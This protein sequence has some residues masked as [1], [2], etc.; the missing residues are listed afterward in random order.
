V[1]DA[2]DRGRCKCRR[3]PNSC[4]SFWR[5]VRGGSRIP[6]ERTALPEVRRADEAYAGPAEHAPTGNG[7]RDP[8][9]RLWECWTTVSRTARE[10]RA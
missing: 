10:Y 4:G 1:A 8:G 2:A 7:R 9:L 6:R 3:S 5:T